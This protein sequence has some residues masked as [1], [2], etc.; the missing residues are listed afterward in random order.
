[1]IYNTFVYMQVSGIRHCNACLIRHDYLHEC[2][3]ASA[4]VRLLH[5]LTNDIRVIRID[6]C[7]NDA[8]SDVC[9]ES[10]NMNESIALVN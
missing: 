5:I 9:N 10:W 6:L 4:V 2:E 7:D 1:M 3:K 8:H